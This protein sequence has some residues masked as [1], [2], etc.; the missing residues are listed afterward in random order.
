[1]MAALLKR[2]E[3]LVRDAQARRVSDVADRLS[4][5][6]GSGAVDVEDA[7]VIVRG[8]SLIKRWLT[9]PQ[10]RFLK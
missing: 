9:D 4:A 7:R 5:M 1:M 3:E 8:R 10:L 2:G 6:F